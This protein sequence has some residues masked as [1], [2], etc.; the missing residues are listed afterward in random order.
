MS[1]QSHTWKQ[2]AINSKTGRDATPVLTVMHVKTKIEQAIVPI[3]VPLLI[4][5]LAQK[6]AA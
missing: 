3:V 6:E 2:R 5:R 1:K 4:E